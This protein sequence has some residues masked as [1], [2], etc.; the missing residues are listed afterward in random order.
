MLKIATDYYINLFRK[1]DRHDITLRSDFFSPEE[2]VTT[3]E[4]VALE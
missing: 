2:K 1:E 3:Q 4:N